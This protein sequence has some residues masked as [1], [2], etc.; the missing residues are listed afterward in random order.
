MCQDCATMF[1][2]DEAGEITDEVRVC[3]DTIPESEIWS[4]RIDAA[5]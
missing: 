4:E 2:V 5:W 1:T 3:F